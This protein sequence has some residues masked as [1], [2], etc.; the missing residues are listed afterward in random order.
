DGE[1]PTM[2]ADLQ[3]ALYGLGDSLLLWYKEISSSRTQDLHQLV[4]DD[5]ALFHVYF[6]KRGVV[7]VK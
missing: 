7:V 5:F 4:V 6:A 3:K 1:D 2:V